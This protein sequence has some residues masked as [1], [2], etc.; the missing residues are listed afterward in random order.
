[1]EEVKE[2]AKSKSSRGRKAEA[3]QTVVEKES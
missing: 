2:E 3:K 1:V